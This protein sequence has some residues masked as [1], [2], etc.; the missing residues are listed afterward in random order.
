MDEI[1]LEI[2]NNWKIF[3]DKYNSNSFYYKNCWDEANSVINIIR[4]DE[5]KYV[6]FLCRYSNLCFS[7]LFHIHLKSFG[8][9]YINNLLSKWHF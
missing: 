4:N 3:N 6:G 1:E 8:P 7:I 5:Y 2:N 9:C